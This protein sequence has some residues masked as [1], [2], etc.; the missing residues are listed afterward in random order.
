MRYG[1]ASA[2]PR[3]S[4]FDRVIVATG[5][6]ANHDGLG[7]ERTGVTLDER[8]AVVVDEQL[9]TTDPRILAVGDVVRF[10]TL[11]RLIPPGQTAMLLPDEAGEEFCYVEPF[12]NK[13]DLNEAWPI[14]SSDYLV[15]QKRPDWSEF[16]QG[17]RRKQGDSEQ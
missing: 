16:E 11:T 7:L 4:A 5:R 8:G 1:V 15:E 2:P 9:R 13:G 6:R 17:I 3:T 14:V 12:L 10:P